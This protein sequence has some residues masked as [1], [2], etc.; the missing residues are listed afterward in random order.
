V[1]RKMKRR[2]LPEDEMRFS[3]SSPRLGGA[4]S[5]VGGRVKVC[6]RQNS[7]VSV[8]LRLICLDS[9]IVRLRLCVHVESFRPT[10]IFIDDNC[11][12]GVL[13]FSL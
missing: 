1:L 13:V 6:L 8:C 7:R 3:T 2:Q 9:V 11:C 10:L 4:S 5:V 12:S